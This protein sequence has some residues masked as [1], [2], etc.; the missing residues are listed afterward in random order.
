MSQKELLPEKG[1]P[2]TPI[3]VLI[4][5][6]SE[7][8]CLLLLQHLRRSG[9]DPAFQRVD[10]AEPMREALV[11]RSWDLVIADH[12]MPSFSAAAALEVLRQASLDIPFIVVSGSV[13][14]DLAV[15]MMKAGA[16]DYIMKNNLHRLVP[17]IERELREARDR[18]EKRRVEQELLQ[19]QQM[20][21]AVIEGSRDGIAVFEDTR[22]LFCNPAFA[23]LHGYES[24][25]TLFGNDAEEVLGKE[26]TLQLRSFQQAQNQEKP[27]TPLF[28]FRFRRRDGEEMELEASVSFASIAGKS[29]LVAVIRDI[30]ERRRLEEQLR[31]SQ[32]MDALGKLAG[33]VVHDFNN[34]LTAITGYSELA[35]YR[36]RADDPLRTELNEIQKAAERAAGLTRQLLAFSRKQSLSL[37]VLNL[38]T[39]MA[40]IEK[41]LVRLIGEHIDLQTFPHESLGQIKADPGQVE[42]VILNLAV[43][44]RDAMPDGGKLTLE[45][46]NVDLDASFSQQRYGLRAGRWVM[47]AVTD[48]GCGMDAETLSHIFEPFFTTKEEGRGT[49]LGLSTV[50][51]IVE[52]VGGHIDVYS[53]PSRGTTFKIYFPRIDAAEEQLP[54]EVIS[55]PHSS[56]SETVLL[57]EDDEMVRNL[58]RQVL[59]REGY[60][61]LE[62]GS[63]ANA[64]NLLQEHTESIHLLITDI[65]MP[66]MNGWE[67]A[68]RV[69]QLRPEVKTL[70]VS[71]YTEGA[72][73]HQ[74]LTDKSVN[75]IQKPFS[76]Q[77]LAL[78]VREALDN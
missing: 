12:N 56:V 5:E 1:N 72:L 63:G 20:L 54:E 36:L 71:G 14:E 31:Q 66:E 48:T 34:L 41:M 10:T 64:L 62:A 45:T 59:S 15:R 6:D 37:K 76:P 55:Q 17:A 22:L 57:V 18:R 38:N 40:E 3:R 77:A 42:Q 26:P 52:Q 78:K 8:D 19:S 69:A 51:A 68:Q 74:G 7:D 27:P 16:H 61:V 21:S 75:F 2:S 67:L 33:G 24:S 39:I 4:V 70:F 23:R 25:S 47:L 11:R 35:L 43:N 46:A 29:H 44:A 28:E 49:G 58:V 60:V 73:L 65:V 13:G 32:K 9:F 50:Y 53:E 30:R